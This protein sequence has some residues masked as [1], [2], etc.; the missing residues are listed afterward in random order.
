MISE[1]VHLKRRKN[2]L[3]MK[4]WDISYTLNE[5]KKYLCEKLIYL[6]QYLLFI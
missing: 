4:K 2:F 1:Y 3:Y 5:T 6:A